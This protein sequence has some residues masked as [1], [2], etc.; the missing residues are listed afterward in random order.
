VSP[1]GTSGP[2]VV[3]GD[4]VIAFMAPDHR[5]EDAETPPA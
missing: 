1:E 3:K 2:S 4:S 5:Q